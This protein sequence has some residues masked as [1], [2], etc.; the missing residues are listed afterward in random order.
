MYL[1]L[2]PMLA[3]IATPA[4]QRAHALRDVRVEF[5]TPGRGRVRELVAMLARPQ[6]LGLILPDDFRQH[7]A[8]IEMVKVCAYQMGMDVFPLTRYPQ[9]NRPAA[10]TAV[11]PTQQQAVVG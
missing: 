1:Y 4:L 10:A 5:A 11:P 9:N 7:N 8:T 3:N 6:C 2:T